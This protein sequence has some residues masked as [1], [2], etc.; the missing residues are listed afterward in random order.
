MNMKKALAIGIIA[1]FIGLSFTPMSSATVEEKE[2]RIP[3]QISSLAAN[4]GLET[5]IISLSRAEALS[6][7]DLMD[8]LKRMDRRPTDLVDRVKDIFGKDDGLLDNVGLLSKLPGNPIV[9]IGEGRELISRYHGR[10]Q[11]KKFVSMWNYPGDA[12]ATVIWGNGL[13]APPTQILLQKQFG[14]MIGFVGL[15]VYIPPLLENMNSKTCFVG[16]S[17]FAWGISA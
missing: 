13:T 14:I 16:S 8:S 6:L 17:L 3:I 10:V 2:T 1:L 5:K 15:Y 11:L 4:G 9:S 12:G 7:A